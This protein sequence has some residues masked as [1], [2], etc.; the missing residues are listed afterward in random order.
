MSANLTC[1]L[2]EDQEVEEEEEEDDLQQ[3]VFSICG[4]WREWE[5]YPDIM[6]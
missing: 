6:Q 4:S 5:G 2:Q 3:P 1:R